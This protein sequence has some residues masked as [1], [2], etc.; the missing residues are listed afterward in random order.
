[1]SVD[2][3]RTVF[4]DIK[5]TTLK[6]CI[7]FQYLWDW[8]SGNWYRSELELKGH[9]TDYLCLV[10]YDKDHHVAVT[11]DIDD[12]GISRSWEPK[13]TDTC[14]IGYRSLYDIACLVSLR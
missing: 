3:D 2:R 1:M 13:I 6:V 11:R 7:Q 9:A 12:N 4:P 5:F 10:G 14:D 8:I